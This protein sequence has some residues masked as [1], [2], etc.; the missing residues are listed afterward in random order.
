[1]RKTLTTAGLAV[2]MVGAGA[3][4]AVA[5]S[6]AHWQVAYVSPETG[7]DDFGL[8]DVAAIGRNDVWAVGSRQKGAGA[9]GVVLHWNGRTWREVRVPG[10]TGSFLTIGGSSPRDVWMLGVDQHGAETAWHWNGFWWRSTSIA[11]FRAGD[12]TVVSRNDAWAAGGDDAN[13]N[14]KATVLH[15]DGKEWNRVRM[16]HTALRISA[17]SKNNV[18]AVGE[19]SNDQPYAAHWN[20]A[21]WTSLKL[22]KVSAPKGA[23]GFSYF[24]DVATV[25]ANN[26]WV[27]G[28]LYYRLHGQAGHNRVVLMRWNGKKWSLGVGTTG[29]FAMSAASDGAGGIWYSTIYEKLVHRTKSGH[30]T[31]YTAPVPGGRPGVEVRRIAGAPG[32]KVFAVGQVQPKP[33][34]TDRSWDALIEQ[35]GN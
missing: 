8:N 5:A 34:G 2:L 30:S 19:G 32:G 17:V 4:P 20:G 12:V 33:G 13:D 10:S 3:V 6:K 35:Y 27:V 28:R 15:W 16:P 11:G 31:T 26:V 21:K 18:W 1:M 29:D 14:A 7:Y 25:S 22:P 23:T 9:S 24:N